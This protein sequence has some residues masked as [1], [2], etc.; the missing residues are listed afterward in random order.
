MTDDRSRI[1]ELHEA[2]DAILAI[3]ARKERQSLA[4]MHCYDRAIAALAK[5]SEEGLPVTLGIVLENIEA[6]GETGREAAKEFPN[7]VNSQEE[8]VT[9]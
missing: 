6:F 8:K 3:L 4:G 7:W 9:W 2:L 1:A 5:G